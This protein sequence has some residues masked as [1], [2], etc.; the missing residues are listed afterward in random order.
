MFT[1]DGGTK[2]L[3]HVFH[4]GKRAGRAFI[5]AYNPKS[6]EHPDASITVELNQ[7]SRGKGI[8]SVAFQ[9]ASY[10]SNYSEV[11]ASI[12]KKNIA[13]KIAC[14]RAGFLVLEDEPGKELVM[15]WRRAAS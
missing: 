3:W 15:V 1:P 5:V 6:E 7:Q 13:S 14:S 2:L 10:L 8:G 4:K 9:K 12:S 11:Y